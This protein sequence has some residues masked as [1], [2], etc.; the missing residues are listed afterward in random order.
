MPRCLTTGCGA[1]LAR[2]QYVTLFGH[3][4]N[5]VPHFEPHSKGELWLGAVKHIVTPRIVF[6]NK[7]AV[8]DSDRARRFTGLNLSGKES[9]TSIGIGYM[10]ESYAD[11]GFVGMF[12]PV[13]LLGALMGRIYQVVIRNKHS[14]LL[15]TA[16]ATAML[17]SV[18]QAF[19]TSNA[20]ILGSLIVLSLA[21]WAL[22]KAFGDQLM[23]WLKRA[24]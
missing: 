7:A 17:F 3:T 11:F 19:A 13:F 12:V 8:D 6:R 14:A 4:L 10:A 23:R 9:S 16:I 15:G 18:L 24:S 21:Y 20:K 5:H 22:N 1:L 2:V